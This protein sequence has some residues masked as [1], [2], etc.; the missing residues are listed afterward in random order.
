[1]SHHSEQQPLLSQDNSSLN[2]IF[3]N[4]NDNDNDNDNDDNDSTSSYNTVIYY[5]SDNISDRSVGSDSV[6]YNTVDNQTNSS[7]L[8]SIESVI[9]V[10]F[11]YKI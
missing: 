4:N 7:S 3:L 6:E 9:N 2:N 1:M 5:N 11:V 10:E 8:L